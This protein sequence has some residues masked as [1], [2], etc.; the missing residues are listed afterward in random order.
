MYVKVICIVIHL[1]R[2]DDRYR[3][4]WKFG[5]CCS[6]GKRWTF[7][8]LNMAGWPSVSDLMGY[9]VY[10]WHSTSVCWPLKTQFESGP[11][12][13]NLTTNVV[14]SYKSLINDVQPPVLLTHLIHMPT[15][16]TICHV[17]YVCLT[18]LPITLYL[19]NLRG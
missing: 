6:P 10:L 3:S 16:Y 8:A 13:A 11:V 7:K 2:F 18:F 12:T 15:I 9:H 19:S 1:R 17:L 5:T 14:Y 4:T